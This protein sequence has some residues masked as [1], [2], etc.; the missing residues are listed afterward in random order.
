MDQTISVLSALVNGSTISVS[1]ALAY[2]SDHLCV[3]CSCLWIRP[4]PCQMHFLM[5]QNLHAKCTCLLI[6][7]FFCSC[8]NNKYFFF[9]QIT[10]THIAIALSHPQ[11]LTSRLHRPHMDLYVQQGLEVIPRAW[12]AAWQLRPLLSTDWSLSS[13]AW[14]FTRQA[15]VPMTAW[16]CQETHH[17]VSQQD[18]CNLVQEDWG[19]L[20]LYNKLFFF[21]VNELQNISD[22]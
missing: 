1:I 4:S 5:D 16:L 8:R 6:W 20:A 21:T 19:G 11:S 15:V 14:R 17:P 10:S 7:V 3:K 22:K 12:T 9:L 2:R 18:V 13:I